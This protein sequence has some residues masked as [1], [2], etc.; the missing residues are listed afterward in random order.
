[1]RG[2]AVAAR[3]A[4]NPKVLGSNPSPATGWAVVKRP[5]YHLNNSC[6]H[7]TGNIYNF[8]F[9]YRRFDNQKGK[10]YFVD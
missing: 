1:M 5:L 9:F 3:R 6:Y 2:G 7:F 8:R 10:I 4:H